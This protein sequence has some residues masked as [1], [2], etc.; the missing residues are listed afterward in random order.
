MKI[1]AVA[2][3]W[4]IVL[5]V[6]GG[7]FTWFALPL[8]RSIAQQSEALPLTVNLPR[9]RDLTGGQAHLYQLSLL[10]EQY[11]Q[12]EVEQKGIDVVVRLLTADNKK[13]AEVDSPTGSSGAEILAFVTNAAGN[14]LVEVRSLEKEAASGKYE[15][16]LAELRNARPNDSLLV[17]ARQAASD[18]LLLSGQGKPDEAL[19]LAEKVL[20][21]REKV[22]GAEDPDVAAALNF[23]AGLYFYKGEFKR[24]EPMYVRAL[25]LREKAL[26]K[27]HEDVAESVND[28]AVTYLNLG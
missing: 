1:V 18:A 14:Y 13:L 27:E 10:A 9:A 23:L 11:L 26:G 17:E 15:I 28:L 21:L 25:A 16:K 6:A 24:A 3:F 22:L 20:A 12:I 4:R 19:P 2:R 7:L 5:V 8:N